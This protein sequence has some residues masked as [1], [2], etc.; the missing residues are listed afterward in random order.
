MPFNRPI[1]ESKTRS[2]VSSGMGVLIEAEKAMQ[3]AL[4]L[5]S[6]VVIGWLGG[7]WLDS[8]L[9]QSWIALAGIIL[10]SISGLVGIIRIALAA[11][12]EPETENKK[13]NGTEKGSPDKDL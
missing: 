3:M 6:A 2:K 1:P 9:H 12:A 8:R 5:P 11:G 4:L 7:A 10:G 13:G